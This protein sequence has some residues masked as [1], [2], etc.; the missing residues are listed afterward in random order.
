ARRT[1]WKEGRALAAMGRSFGLDDVSAIPRMHFAAAEQTEVN[2][3]L[4]EAGLVTPFAVI[5]PDTNREWFGELRAWPMERWQAL[6]GRLR[7]A[8]PDVQIVQVGLGR[9]G[10]VG[11]VVDLTGRT[12]FRQAALIIARSA[13][14]I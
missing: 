3:L 6:V 8:R 10:V 14:F 4:L 2:R 7:E 9:S 1:I 5:E 13:L 11:G 12:T